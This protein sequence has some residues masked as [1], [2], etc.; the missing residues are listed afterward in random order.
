MYAS[1]LSSSLPVGGFRWL[2]AREVEDFDVMGVDA[3]PEEGTSYICLVDLHYP[4]HLCYSHSQVP[5]APEHVTITE[6]LLSPSTRTLRKKIDDQE[7]L[8]A[9]RL[10]A[11]FGD[12]LD[13]LV[14]LKNLQFYLHMG[15]RITKLKRIFAY[16]CRPY[17]KPFI[18]DC[19]KQRANARSALESRFAKLTMNRYGRGKSPW[20]VGDLIF[21]LVSSCYGKFIEDK[22]KYLTLKLSTC[23][24]KVDKWL[25]S[26]RFVSFRKVGNLFLVFLR[27]RTV[28]MDTLLVS[29]NVDRKKK[30]KSVFF[31]FFSNRFYALGFVVLEKSKYMLQKTYYD[32]VNVVWPLNTVILS[33][34]GTCSGRKSKNRRCLCFFYFAFIIILLQIRIVFFWKRKI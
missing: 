34:T 16:K 4:P 6:D 30:K 24:Q 32:H 20:K 1:V 9:R 8:N 12:R 23:P 28:R 31:P 5:L 14:H 21:F 13:Y 33:D 27:P 19:M 25:A 2:T 26:P 18:D 11:T 22:S 29:G 3:D 7:K 15:L 10:T 17:G